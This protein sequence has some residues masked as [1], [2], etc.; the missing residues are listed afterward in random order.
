MLR[1]NQ[2][3]FPTGTGVDARTY[4]GENTN[5][6]RFPLSEP[7]YSDDGQESTSM[8]IL[9]AHEGYTILNHLACLVVEHP[10]SLQCV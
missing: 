7:N 10:T 6:A 3:V 2:Y 1:R 4:Q 9:S 8:D 5:R